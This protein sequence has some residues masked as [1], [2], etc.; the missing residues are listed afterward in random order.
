LNFPIYNFQCFLERI[1]NRRGWR[2]EVALSW[3][4][5]PGVF[6]LASTNTLF[7]QLGTLIVQTRF[8]ALRRAAKLLPPIAPANREVPQ[9]TFQFVHYIDLAVRRK[10]G[11]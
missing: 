1:T 5:R 10:I 11:R 6:G 4:R 8:D 9:C 2:R 3:A 7:A